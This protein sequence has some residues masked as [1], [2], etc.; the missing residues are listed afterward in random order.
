[1]PKPHDHTKPSVKIRRLSDPAK[2]ARLTVTFEWDSH[3]TESAKN[4]GA[5]LAQFLRQTLT[6]EQRLEFLH[7]FNEESKK[8][9]GPRAS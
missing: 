3:D 4:I 9:L 1:M 6:E 7:R 8:T 2:P 5:A